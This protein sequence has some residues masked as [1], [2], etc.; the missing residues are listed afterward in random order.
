MCVSIRFP[1]TIPLRNISSGKIV[2]A[3]ITYFNTIGLSR[4]LQS[5]Q[6]P[7]FSSKTFQQVVRQLEISPVGSRAYHPPSQGVLGRFQSTLKNMIRTYCLNH[8]NE[9]DEGIPFFRSAVLRICSRTI[10]IQ[11]IPVSIRTFGPRSFEIFKR[12]LATRR[13]SI[14]ISQFRTWMTEA[15]E[16]AREKF[17]SKK[18]KWKY[19]YNRKAA[20][21][22]FNTGDKVLVLLPID[23][24]PHKAQ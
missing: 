17:R 6:E 24:H 11:H 21:R 13:N 10:R 14:R 9:W 12:K 3:L 22:S 18:K 2:K 16:L 15:S 7:S 4:V 20:E 5:D 19:R 1:E 8:Q 23:G